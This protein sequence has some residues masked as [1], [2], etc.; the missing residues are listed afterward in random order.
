MNRQEKIQSILEEKKKMI[1]GLN[2]SI[3]KYA[4]GGYQEYRSAAKIKEVLEAEGFQVEE[5][6][7]GIETALIG[8]Y[9]SGSPV[10]GIL[11]EYDALPN[12]SQEAGC[13][14]RRPVEGQQYG[15]GCGHSALG[16]GAVGIP[17]GNR[18]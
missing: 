1:T 16:A 9:G 18:S 14:Q 2:R 7:A 6:A 12:L 3:W 15:H 4:E 13:A 17:E 10:I 8:T 11:A 5:H